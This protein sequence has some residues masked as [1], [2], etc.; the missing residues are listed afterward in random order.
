MKIIESKMLQIEEGKVLVEE[1]KD[2]DHLEEGKEGDELQN[3]EREVTQ[4][5]ESVPI[6]Y[7]AINLM[8]LIKSKQQ[9]IKESHREVTQI[10]NQ[11]VETDA[12]I[13]ER[14]SIQIIIDFKW[15][16][17]SW[18]FFSLQL[19]LFICFIIAFIIDIN[20]VSKNSHIFSSDD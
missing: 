5:K 18:K 17:Y 2:S 3:S 10:M 19:F 15:D 13:L 7:Y 14:E 12:T 4:K 16:S 20:A 11:L 6:E 9:P 1:K 8:Q